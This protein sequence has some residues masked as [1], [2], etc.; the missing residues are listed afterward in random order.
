MA[1]SHCASVNLLNTHYALQSLA[2]TGGGA[3]LGAFLMRQG[4]TPSTVLAAIACVFVGRFLIR[5]LVLPVAVLLGLKWLVLAGLVLCAAQFAI[6]PRVEGVGWWLVAWVV[7]AAAGETS[8]WTA[9]HAYYAALGDAADRGEQ[10]G[11]REAL[12]TIGGIAS[13]IAT[14]WVLTAYGPGAAFGASGVIMLAATIPLLPMANLTV[15]RRAPHALQGAFPAV[16]MF[17]ADGLIQAGLFVVWPLVLF[18][19]LSGSYTAYASTIAAA[20]IASAIC[21]VWFGRFIDLG[22]GVRAVWLFLSVLSLVVALRIASLGDPVLAVIGAIAGAV[23]PA[24]YASALMTPIYNMAKTSE[25]PLRFNIA[26][27]GGADVGTAAGCLAAA[28]ALSAGA[29]MS[30][31]VAIALVGIPPLGALLIFYYRGRIA[32]TVR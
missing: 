20:S 27:E 24:F 15:A 7:V 18:Q 31:S 16:A 17:T 5:P 23:L 1:Q 21:G 30:A 11:T 10:V 32:L 25:C 6:L 8:Y 26:T 4:L 13:P 14:G 19:A 22:H 12:V 9:Y 2:I 3:F 28:V 29:P